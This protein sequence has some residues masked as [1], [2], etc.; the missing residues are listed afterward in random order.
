VHVKK[1]T[2]CTAQNL[3]RP[4]KISTRG[5]N[6]HFPEI[7]NKTHKTRSREFQP[8]FVR[9]FFPLPLDHCHIR[10]TS[11]VFRFSKIRRLALGYNFKPSFGT[12]RDNGRGLYRTEL[13]AQRERKSL[14]V[15]SILQYL[16]STGKIARSTC[17]SDIIKLYYIT[18]PCYKFLSH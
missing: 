14:S 10:Q 3:T 7:V 8:E 17:T 5:K 15:L 12:S 9:L 2:F 6:I 16:F 11:A 18:D 4:Q 1:A 13:L